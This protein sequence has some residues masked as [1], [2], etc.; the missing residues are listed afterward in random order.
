MLVKNIK[1]LIKI[2]IK[3]IKR[4]I[5]CIKYNIGKRKDTIM[6]RITLVGRLVKKPETKLVGEKNYQIAK[7]CIAVDR[8]KKNANGE[9]ETDFIN[10]VLWGNQ[11]KAF[12]QYLD[13]GSRISVDGA[14]RVSSYKDT[15]NITNIYFC[16]NN[17]F[18]LSTNIILIGIIKNNK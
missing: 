18:F 13:K 1:K 11:A 4:A 5:I 2:G 9:K 14:L 15:N 16:L 8:Y 12:E 3:K 10:L 17:L 7:G 6:N